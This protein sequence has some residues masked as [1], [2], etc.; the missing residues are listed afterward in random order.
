MYRKLFTVILVLSVMNVNAQKKEGLQTKATQIPQQPK[1]DYTQIGA[2]MPDMI[3]VTMDTFYKTVKK[4]GN[5]WTRLRHKN[6]TV[7]KTNT[8]SNEDFNNGA[9]LFVMMFNPTCSHCIEET[10]IMK[11]NMNLFNKSKV[12][13]MAN[14]QMKAYLPD[15]VKQQNT[16][17][18]PVF[19][20]GL[21]SLN[22]VNSAFLY[23]SLPQINI[24][25]KER[26]LIKIYNGDVAID[27]L[28]PFIQ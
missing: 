14:K 4:D 3:L 9:N 10:E 22:F 12:I 21:D 2:P 5:W 24:Y 27:S 6:E 13:L 8:F 7:I 20:V 16:K 11:R 15:F 17:K 1:I 26:K 18:F 19:T 25:N 28:K 23:R